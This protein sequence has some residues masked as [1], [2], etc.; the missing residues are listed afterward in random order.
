MD[1]FVLTI[2]SAAIGFG[3]SQAFNFVAFVRRPKFRVRHWS[4]GVISS[5]TGDPPETPWEIELG[6]FLENHGANI[7]KNV[8]VFVSDIMCASGLDQPLETTSIGIL[9]LKRP[10]NVIPPGECVQIKLG[11]IRS[12]NRELRLFLH[13]DT[14]PDALEMI[15]AETREKTRFLAK[16]YISCDDKNTLKLIVLEFRPDENEWASL[17]LED[18]SEPLPQPGSAAAC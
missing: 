10:I 7:A 15:E 9:E 12:D 14:D 13:S 1:K 2:F 11:V 4:D 3:F 18:Y 17:L 6:F 5:Y 16:F 8:R